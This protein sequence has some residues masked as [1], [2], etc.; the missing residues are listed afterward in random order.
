MLANKC[1]VMASLDRSDVINYG[2]QT[3][4]VMARNKE[5]IDVVQLMADV[6]RANL[7]CCL[8]KGYHEAVSSFVMPCKE[9]C[10]RT[11]ET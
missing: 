6:K 3:V 4:P 8:W 7:T 5:T 11:E 10:P 2:E 1:R 9:S